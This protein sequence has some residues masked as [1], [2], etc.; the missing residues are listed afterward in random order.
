MKTSALEGMI[1]TARDVKYSPTGALIGG[2]LG[3]LLGAWVDE[4]RRG[5]G[6]L[7]GGI[8]GA[9]GGTASDIAL[10]ADALNREKNRVRSVEDN[11]TLRDA[12]DRMNRFTE[13]ISI[14]TKREFAG[15]PGEDYNDLRWQDRSDMGVEMFPAWSRPGVSGYVNNVDDDGTSTEGPLVHLR[16]Q[17]LG[18]K[19]NLVTTL[20][21]ENNHWQNIDVADGGSGR[22][23][24][25]MKLLDDA[26]NFDENDLGDET[27]G[28]PLQEEG[29][30]N[31][32]L[33]ALLWQ[34]L[35][36]RLG[37]DATYEEF[38]DYISNMTLSDFWEQI[39]DKTDSGYFINSFINGHS[40]LSDKKLD[41]FVRNNFIKYKP[42]KKRGFRF[43]KS[44]TE[45]ENEEIG[46]K[47]NEMLIKKLEEELEKYKRALREVA[48]T[49]RVKYNDKG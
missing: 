19:D 42:E 16:D 4:D 18:D 31:A 40:G 36:D 7:L 43:W 33:R 9:L 1:K 10:Y 48:K 47:N 46:R 25:E 5:R 3:A 35:S 38:K 44:D 32:E 45:K 14:P 13:N 23:A 41:E 27:D 2:G 21:H 12:V 34:S 20:A 49:K 11:A 17:Y 24:R 37:R 39:Y 6:A 15:D 22:S 29:A 8:L 26:Y 30:T 28:T